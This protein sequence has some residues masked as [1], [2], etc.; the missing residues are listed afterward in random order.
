[1]TE[2]DIERDLQNFKNGV[3]AAISAPGWE[4]HRLLL[5]LYEERAAQRK[6][7]KS[8]VDDGVISADNVT[9][10]EPDLYEVVC[11]MGVASLAAGDVVRLHSWR[12]P[13]H[14]LQ[15]F[16]VRQSDFSTHPIQISEVYYVKLRKIDNPENTSI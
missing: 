2:R 9:P 13:Q 7:V 6:G 10:N 12:H 3:G 15:H 16:F 11:P 4:Y 5:H 1:M 14:G 8:E